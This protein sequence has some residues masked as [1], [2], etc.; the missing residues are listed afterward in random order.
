MKINQKKALFYIC[1]LFSIT[2]CGQDNR[3]V[4][5]YKGTEAYELAKAIDYADLRKIEVLVKGTPNLLNAFSTSPEG[6]TILDLCIDVEKIESLKKILE[7]GANANAKQKYGKRSA[8][9]NAC[10]VF[11]G[12][13]KQ[14]WKTDTRYAELLIKYGADV[15]YTIDNDF[16]DENQMHHLAGSPII[17]ASSLDLEIIKLLIKN[18]ADYKKRVNGELPFGH[19]LYSGKFENM[20]Y[21]IDSLKIRVHEP[22]YIS[23]NGKQK[24]IQDFIRQY[25][26]YEIDSEGYAKT[27]ILV[28]KLEKIGVDFKN[29]KYQ[30]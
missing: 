11:Y 27:Q 2:S 30:E 17:E 7:L 3:Y 22:L 14:P 5:Y 16:E 23:K 21:F 13:G 20:Y 1:V 4:N 12:D 28:K 25:F 10:K 19:V 15:N 8:L 29:Y 6:A 18:G 9:M 26:K 24:Y